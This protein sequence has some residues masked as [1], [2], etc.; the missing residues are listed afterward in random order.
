MPSVVPFYA[1]DQG[2]VDSLC[3][4]IQKLHHML[5][6][7]EVGLNLTEGEAKLYARITQD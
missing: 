5:E 4:I 1:A 2:L 6:N 7:D 3:S